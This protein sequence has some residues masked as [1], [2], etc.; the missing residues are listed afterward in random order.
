MKRALNACLVTLAL[1]YS[2]YGQGYVIE[3]VDFYSDGR[4]L[5]YQL[6]QKADIE[7]GLHFQDRTA[8]DAFL[9]DRTQVLLNERVLQTV[10]INAE[11]GTPLPDGRIPVTVYVSTK[12]TWN[13]IA[14]P[15]FRYDSNTGLLLSG[16]ARDYNFLGSMEALR[17][18]LN[19]E[20]DTGGSV[21]WG[22]DA[23]FSFPFPAFG[24]DWNWALEGDF[25]LP[26]DGGPAMASTGTALQAALPFGPGNLEFEL[27]QT[28]LFNQQ[29]DD[30]VPYTDTFYLNTAGSVG[31]SLP[32]ALPFSR[33]LAT[34]RPALGVGLDWLPGGLTDERLDRGSALG[35][36]L[37]I[38]HGRIDWHG[39]FRQGQLVSANAAASFYPVDGSYERSVSLEA[40]A[41]MDAGWIGPSV[42]LYGFWNPDDDSDEAGGVVRGVINN[43]TDTDVALALNIDL[44]VR[45]L[46]FV[47]YEWFGRNWMK[48]FQFE[49]HWSPF[50]DASLGHY[51]GTWFNPADG[52]YGAGL[53][54][55][56]FPLIMRS[57][58]VRISLGWSVADVLSTSS[59]A[60]D[61]PRDGKSVS[62]FYFGLGHHY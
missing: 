57:F 17:L 28:A 60:E 40:S 16:R 48:L 43:R 59:L 62:E 45:V 31:W 25:S 30:D 19:L 39:N 44:P 49:Q 6:S 56:T 35:A 51:D 15:Y 27:S 29:D 1:S 13:I 4:T 46:R 18:N 8:L 7:A 50:L 53:E 58:Y 14:L 36:N 55:I 47:P 2:A 9:A 20:Q 42:R 26:D 5:E 38:A 3:S 22:A 61:S 41:F 32:V 37:G 12:D 23:D 54:V 52:W 33:T 34:L 24:L 11:E 21:F 10:L